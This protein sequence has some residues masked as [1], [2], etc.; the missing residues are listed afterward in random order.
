MT[1]KLNQSSQEKFTPRDSLNDKE[2]ESL[3]SEYGR[4]NFSRLNYEKDGQLIYKNIKEVLICNP[5]SDDSKENSTKLDKLLN[6]LE[7]DESALSDIEKKMIDVEH[8]LGYN[9]DNSSRFDNCENDMLINSAVFY[10]KR[11]EVL[12]EKS[13]NKDIDKNFVDSIVNYA[14]AI[15]HDENSNM[16]FRYDNLEDRQVYIQNCQRRRSNCHNDMINQFNQL[17]NLS[18][19][20]GL[21]PLTYR[22]LITNSSSN[23]FRNNAQM[24][25]DRVT[26]ARYVAGVIQLGFDQRLP[27]PK[28]IKET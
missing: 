22:N 10:H 6:Y 28:Y 21:K 7:L 24:Y 11:I 25:H 27:D 13:G 20:N 3:V 19:I 9:V 5:D 14:R 16:S 12:R 18:V 17:N 4:L 15:E 2:K 23:N 1:E 26:I 8:S